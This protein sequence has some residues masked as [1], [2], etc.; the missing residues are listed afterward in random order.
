MYP[1]FG[2]SDGTAGGRLRAF[3]HRRR[4]FPAGGTVPADV[5]G[6]GPREA[7]RA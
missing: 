1:S 3:L 7:E 5:P 2:G 4:R 6:D